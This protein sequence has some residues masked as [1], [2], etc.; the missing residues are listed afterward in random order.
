VLSVWACLGE[1]VKASSPSVGS[2]PFALGSLHFTGL[3]FGEP[4]S[5][6]AKG[7]RTKKQLRK[8]RVHVG[9]L[10]SVKFLFLPVER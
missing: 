10:T 9:E 2:V 7:K 3:C 4:T 8:T 1:S 5:L 6:K